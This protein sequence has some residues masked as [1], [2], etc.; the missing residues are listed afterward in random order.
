MMGDS[1]QVKRT[2][3]ASG[4]QAVDTIGTAPREPPWAVGDPPAFGRT[5]VRREAGHAAAGTARA[6]VGQDGPTAFREVKPRR[7]VEHC[8]SEEVT[9][10]DLVREQCR[11]ARGEELGYGDPEVRGHSF[12]FR[13]TGED[14]GRN[15]MP[16]PG[17]ITPL[18]YPTGPGLRVHSGQEE[19]A[20]ICGNF[21]SM[22]P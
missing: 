6:R 2:F 1:R 8:V 5:G 13:I 3:D 10:I 19:G 11:L 16:A 12:E 15:F 7:Q 9:G 22:L 17:V 4:V 14:P 21:D 20:D 18:Q